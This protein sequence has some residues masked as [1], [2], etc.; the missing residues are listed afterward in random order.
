MIF[1]VTA[2]QDCHASQWG[3]CQAVFALNGCGAALPVV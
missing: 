1:K 3:W 2:L